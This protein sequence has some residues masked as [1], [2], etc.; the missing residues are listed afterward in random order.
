MFNDFVITKLFNLFKASDANGFILYFSDHGEDVYQ[1]APHDVLGRNEK[2]PTRA[3]YTIPFMLWQS[4][5]WLTNHPNNF[6]SYVNRKFSTQD[7]IHTW[8]DLA[9]LSFDDYQPERSIVNKDFA[10]PIRWIGD[11]HNKKRL[12]DFDKLPK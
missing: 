4:P 3:M 8:S 5:K 10:Q 6:Q 2:A 12:M 9:G 11:P 7:L 1:T